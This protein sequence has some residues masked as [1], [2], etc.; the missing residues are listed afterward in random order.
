MYYGEIMKIPPECDSLCEYR[1]CYNPAQDGSRCWTR[2]GC[3]CP[4]GPVEWDKN[5]NYGTY[6]RKEPE[7]ISSLE[8][9]LEDLKSMSK[10]KKVNRKIG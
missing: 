7:W 4:D 10:S 5:R 9:I 6:M 3:G 2:S 8:S 1:S